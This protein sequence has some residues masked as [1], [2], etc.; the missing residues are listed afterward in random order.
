VPA[1]RKK[2]LAEKVLATASLRRARPIRAGGG[3]DEQAALLGCE[4]EACGLSIF[5]QRPHADGSQ[6]R[7]KLAFTGVGFAQAVFLVGPPL[8]D[9][10]RAPVEDHGSSRGSLGAGRLAV[11]WCS[12]QVVISP[13][14]AASAGWRLAFHGFDHNDANKPRHGPSLPP[15]SDPAAG[16]R[17][18]GVPGA[19][20]GIA[21]W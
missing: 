5:P 12:W 13:S 16:S 2:A 3:G 21:R 8:Q 1:C 7:S 14:G 6:P 4:L 9:P 19:A 11:I 20:G 18:P 10:G 15:L 17:C